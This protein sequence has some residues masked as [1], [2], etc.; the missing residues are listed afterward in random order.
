MNTAALQLDA[1]SPLPEVSDDYVQT[2]AGEPVVVYPLSVEVD[3]AAHRWELTLLNEPQGGT[4]VVTSSGAVKFA[5]N[6]GFVGAA[7]I[8]F[9][10]EDQKGN[11]RSATITVEVQNQFA[12]NAATSINNGTVGVAPRLDQPNNAT[13]VCA[14]KVFTVVAEPVFAGSAAPNAEL[15]GRLYNQC[16][17]LAGES[18]ATADAEGS[19]EMIFSETRELEFY[20]VEIEQLA[21]TSGTFGEIAL[22]PNEALW[23]AM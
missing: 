23:Q 19:W 21:T 22:Q 11:D 9:V 12:F 2:P 18:M 20:R 1:R 5:P 7:T 10:I 16:G 8:H 17:S 14:R 3:L 13:G 4:T 15:V 6:P